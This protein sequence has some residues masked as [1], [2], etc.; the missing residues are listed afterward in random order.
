MWRLGRSLIAGVQ[1]PG[2]LVLFDPKGMEGKTTFMT[3][4]PMRCWQ[5]VWVLK[6]AAVVEKASEP[7]LSNHDNHEMF[8]LP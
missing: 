1:T 8:K 7:C 3:N 4:K 5:G 2:L 6:Q